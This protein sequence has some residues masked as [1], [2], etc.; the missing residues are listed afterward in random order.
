MTEQ[1]ASTSRGGRAFRAAV[2]VGGTFT[3]VVALDTTSGALIVDKVETTPSEPS[4]GVLESLAKSGAP[5][6]DI[7]YFV[8]GTTLALN[9]LLTRNGARVA[10]V[11]TKG[12]RDVFELGRTDREPM[13]DLTYR[14]P[15]SLV[16]R[17]RVFEAPERLA[18]DGSVLEPVDIDAVRA[19]AERI[20]AAEVQA[21]AV[22]LLHSYSNPEHEVAVGQVLR[23]ELP[24]VD[25]T[26]S[27]EL[28]RV[29]REYER[30]STSVL[31]AY[32]KPVVRH[33]LDMLGD[34]LV[35]RG[36]T[37][38]F[39]MMRSGGGAMTVDAAKERPVNLVLSGPAGGVVGAAAFAEL[40]GAPNLITLDM[41]GTSLDAAIIIGGQP[42]V[43]T[44]A[45]FQGLPVS[46]PTL[47]INTI[48]AGGG[49]I[50][51]VDAGDHL[52]VGPQSAGADPGPASYGRGGTEPTVTD[53]ALAAGY[54][55]SDT[56]LG[57]ELTLDR[58][59][60]AGSMTPIAEKMGISGDDVAA[61]MLR[62]ATT[63]VVGA[64]R[65]ITVERGHSPADF[66]ILS[67]G[68]AGGIIAADT[69]RE[70]GVPRVIVP[71]GPGAF[72]AMGMLMADVAHDLARTR[73]TDLAAVDAEGLEADYRELE[74]LAEAALESDGFAETDRALAR[75]ADIRYQGQEHTVAIPL[76]AGVI[77]EALAAELRE[78]FGV[79]HETQYGHRTEDPVEIVTI[80]VRGSGLVPR[81][82]LPRMAPGDAT[83][84]ARTRRGVWRGGD[85]G[86]VDYAVYERDALTLGSRLDGPAVIEERTATTVIHAGDSLSVGEHGE[87]DIIIG[88]RL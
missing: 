20:S 34:E 46:L 35:E 29:Y 2:D 67:F 24:G 66:A 14:K 15:E 81:P 52:Q 36:F 17:S 25:I 5:M 33:Y 53:A 22:C 55:G 65:E 11:T 45:T 74:S 49:S 84:V 9:A 75:T 47:D 50:G 44:A 42:T 32:V 69:A 76:P 3:D 78:A 30:T 59:L 70:L 1:R 79:A 88:E 41:G 10:I 4:R 37:G 39:L 31:D 48:G 54:L 72:S 68:G 23:E 6:D 43:T 58:E 28:L 86:R 56:A 71:P 83:P 51:W 13:Y 16:P 87:L 40:V 7:G 21:V 61:G 63:K 60:A 38:H 19:V 80:R 62:I 26:L 27:H 64:V 85:L 18:W 73:I 12:F 82:Q 8:H 57:G 77:D